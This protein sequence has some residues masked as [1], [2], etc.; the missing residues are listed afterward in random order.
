MRPADVAVVVPVYNRAATVLGALKTVADQSTPPRRV[1]VVDDGSVD[2]TAAAVS[3]WAAS[4]DRCWEVIVIRQPNQGAGAAR[5]RGFAVLGD[6]RY[7]AFLDS[8]DHWPADFLSRAVAKME[9]DQTAVAATADRLF[10]RQRKRRLGFHSSR[11]IERNAAA[12]LMKHNAGIA[13]CSLFRADAIRRLGGFNPSIPSGQDAE[14]F[15]RLS[16]EG[17]WLHVPGEPVHFYVGFSELKG[18]EANLSLKYADRKRRWARIRER[19]I[20]H[21]DGLKIVP[22]QVYG[23][24]LARSW[25]KTAGE[26]AAQGRLVLAAACYR[27]AVR[28]RPLKISSW[29]RYA[30][31]LAGIRRAAKPILVGRNPALTTNHPETWA[32]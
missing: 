19:F 32:A 5:N 13:S 15:L 7:V 2:G 22:K 30:R 21:Q 16:K 28:Y 1:I 11:Q 3:Q 9:A 18:E 23:R 20:F 25:H 29:W 24:A 12:W 27:K 17:R 8:D 14:L 10:H 6:C 31:L 26:Y 4:V